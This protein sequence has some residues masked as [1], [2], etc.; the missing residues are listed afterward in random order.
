MGKMK[1]K[2][3]NRTSLS[4]KKIFG[5]PKK[6]YEQIN[7]EYGWCGL[8]MALTIAGIKEIAKENENDR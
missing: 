4:D 7:I 2:T 6:F 3:E 8:L 1:I 5:L